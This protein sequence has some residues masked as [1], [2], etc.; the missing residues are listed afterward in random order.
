MPSLVIPSV[1][2]AHTRGQARVAVRATTVGEALAALEERYPEAGAR[3]RQGLARRYVILAVAGMDV[4]HGLGERTAL[5]EESEV[6][7]VWAV[8]GG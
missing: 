6:E 8:A 7:L 3:V 1:L 4:R 2:R 5:T